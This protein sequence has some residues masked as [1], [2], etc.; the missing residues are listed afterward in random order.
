MSRLI[1][2]I[3]LIGVCALAVLCASQWQTNRQLNLDVLR[4]EKA[5]QANESKIAEQ[6]IA[7]RG[8]A[9][10]LDDFRDRL[11]RSDAAL[12]ETNAKLSATAE[13]R[14]R[15]LGERD[16]LKAAIDKW[17]AAVSERD[18][19]L[20]RAGEKMNSIATER[21]DAVGKFNDLAA[22]YNGLVKDLDDARAK[23]AS[24]H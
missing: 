15:L 8:Y 9:A 11:A 16:Q 23:L 20:K 18:A 2:F 6:E 21:N 17:A 10:D 3:N 22:K 14:D 5:R 24:G 1:Q 7:I 13:E 4:L 19:A 12:K